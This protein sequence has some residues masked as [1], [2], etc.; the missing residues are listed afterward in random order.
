[1]ADDARSADQE[2]QGKDPVMTSRHASS[3]LV[4]MPKR[5]ARAEVKKLLLRLLPVLA[6]LRQAAAARDVQRV[7]AHGD[8]LRRW[9]YVYG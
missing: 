8:L 5:S 6:H 2:V 1:V 7:R 9:K 4:V 3:V